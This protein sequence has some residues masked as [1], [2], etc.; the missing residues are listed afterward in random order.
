MTGP[1]TCLCLHVRT[2]WT[3]QTTFLKFGASLPIHWS[4]LLNYIFNILIISLEN[5]IIYMSEHTISLHIITKIISLHCIDWATSG[6]QLSF[7]KCQIHH[8][9]YLT[10]R[11]FQ[12]TFTILTCSI[13]PMTRC[14]SF[15][16]M[17]TKTSIS[18]D[19][20][21][22][23]VTIGLACSLDVWMKFTPTS[24]CKTSMS[25]SHDFQSC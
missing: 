8:L 19:D 22:Q 24:L 21:I 3:S 25:S 18:I 9:M 6:Y 20:K 15:L 17:L 7:V 23:N 12:K 4:N 5:P 1:D 2:V 13:P 14:S 11:N 16:E 10:Q